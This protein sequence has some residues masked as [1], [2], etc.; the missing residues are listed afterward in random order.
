MQKENLVLLY[1]LKMKLKMVRW[2][3]KIVF[4]FFLFVFQNLIS[5][6]EKNVYNNNNYKDKKQF[7]K[8]QKRKKI[9]GGRKINKLKN[10]ELV[11]KLKTNKNLN[12]ELV[13]AV[14]TDLAEKKKLETFF[15]N[16]NIMMAF[17]DHFTFCKLYFI[18]NTK[19]KIQFAK[20]KMVFKCHHYVFIHK[21]SLEFFLFGQIGIHGFY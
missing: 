12:N 7:E 19:N 2:L 21:K 16:K 8:F 4:F 15:M 11:V 1:Q 17:K 6:I 18:F 10:G 14:N 9:I 20:R 13:K 5:Q 3:N